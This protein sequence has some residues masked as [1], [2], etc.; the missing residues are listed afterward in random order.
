MKKIKVQWINDS[1]GWNYQGLYKQLKDHQVRLSTKLKSTLTVCD[2]VTVSAEVVKGDIIIQQ[3]SLGKNSVEINCNENVKTYKVAN[4]KAI[5]AI[6]GCV[7]ETIQF[8]A[9]N[10]QGY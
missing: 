5:A 1:V 2:V 3:S 8:R 4:K 7:N 6:I 10:H 9:D